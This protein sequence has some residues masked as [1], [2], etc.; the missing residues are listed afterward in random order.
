MAGRNSG[1][2]ESTSDMNPGNHAKQHVDKSKDVVRE[3]ARGANPTS[4]KPSPLRAPCCDSETTSEAGP[5]RS[6]LS[7]NAGS[8]AKACE[9][10]SYTRPKFRGTDMYVDEIFLD[11]YKDEIDDPE[12]YRNIALLLPPA[13]RVEP[14]HSLKAC[15][16]PLWGLSTSPHEFFKTRH[17]E[18]GSSCLT[19]VHPRVQATVERFHELK[20]QGIHYN[21]E[22]IKNRSFNNPHVYSQL[23]DLLA[24]DETRSNLPC[25]DTGR[26]QGSWRLTFPLNPEQLV[27]GDP[28][29]IEQRQKKQAD[30]ES[31]T[32]LRTPRN[33]TIHFGRGRVHD[34]SEPEPEP[35][36]ELDRPPKRRSSGENQMR[37]ANTSIPKRRAH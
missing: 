32:K 5:S 1:S 18:A 33:R 28:I 8:K 27:Q 21:Q 31:H 11:D 24:I 16:R 10:R 29:A 30:T 35:E 26:V 7:W 13:Q 36:P 12:L 37:G 20:R 9:Y 25:I 14:G 2:P 3:D 22:L 17:D 6:S 34:E 19:E 4:M 23:V 15:P